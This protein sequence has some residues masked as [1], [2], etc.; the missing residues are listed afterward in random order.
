MLQ[1][2]DEHLIGV[3]PALG[4]VDEQH[5]SG[6]GLRLPSS[7]VPALTSN[8]AS[9]PP[10]TATR[11][12]PVY[13]HFVARCTGGLQW[14]QLR[15]AASPMD[16]T[17]QGGSIRAR[18]LA[19]RE[20]LATAALKPSDLRDGS[21]AWAQFA[22]AASVRPAQAAQIAKEIAAQLG[23]W[24]MRVALCDLRANGNTSTHED[25]EV[26]FSD[27][28]KVVS[29]N[30]QWFAQAQVTDTEISFG[31]GS[32]RWKIDRASAEATLVDV[33]TGKELFAGS[34]VAGPAGA[35]Q[36]KPP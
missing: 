16:L 22:C 4:I 15:E 14:A 19:A 28:E 18:T 26:R 10:P 24:D 3:D 12:A 5:I 6:I 25:V 33:A 29:V 7:S 2:I 1:H 31:N 9:T 21:R 36:R 32:A 23:A 13:V 34:C 35:D 20:A 27:Q 17:P 11:P 30:G 8:Q